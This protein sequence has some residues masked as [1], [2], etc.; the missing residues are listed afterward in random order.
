MS[1][2]TNKV[3]ATINELR[4]EL[5][6][7]YAFTIF[8][9][10]VDAASDDGK[11]AISGEIL[12]AKQLSLL[13]RRLT[14]LSNDITVEYSINIITSDE[15]IRRI[16]NYGEVAK[17]S[18][19]DVSSDFIGNKLATQISL[20]DKPFKIILNNEGK[21][22]ISLSDYTIGW[23]DD[24]AIVPLDRS[25]FDYWANIKRLK[26]DGL[27]EVS[28]LLPIFY[29]SAPFIDMAEYLHGGRS[30]EAVDCSALMQ[31][32]FLS[33][34]DIVLPRHSLDQMKCGIRIPKG[35]IAS[36]DLV[37]ARRKGTR[38]MHVGLAFYH[39]KMFVIHS[40]LREKLVIR[41]DINS[42]FEHYTFAGA[43]RMIKESA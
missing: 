2:N 13:K 6:N 34:Y 23:V 10:K 27:V 30:D 9:L 16:S 40:C 8:D 31:L 42:F 20:C 22:L 15:N 37:F 32:L 26:K 7:K 41:E 12:T 29:E 17:G 19:V 38:I 43:K 18:I 36:G 33:A 1:N 35:D 28:S 21:T 11:I 25:D 5:L 14:D 24:S 4:E 39:E 3:T